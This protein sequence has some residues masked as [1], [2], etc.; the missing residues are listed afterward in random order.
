MRDRLLKIGTVPP[1]AGH[2][3]TLHYTHPYPVS[4]I[5]TQK[6]I[7]SFNHLY[8]LA[9]EEK[10]PCEERTLPW[11]KLG[12][13]PLI[14]MATCSV[15]RTVTALGMHPETDVRTQLP[16]SMEEETVTSETCF[17]APLTRLWDSLPRFQNDVDL[18]VNS[19]SG[20][21]H[22]IFTLILLHAKHW[23]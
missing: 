7:C 17:T 18:Q 5:L 20:L 16:I 9:N 23:F 2:P 12:P 3:V 11:E 8:P 15:R 1:K 19:H 21:K 6:N 22:E 13:W 4:E 14:H 10:L